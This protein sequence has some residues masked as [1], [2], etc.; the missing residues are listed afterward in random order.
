VIDNVIAINN[1]EA[2][3]RLITMLAEDKRT[4][5]TGKQPQALHPPPGLALY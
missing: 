1:P 4:R 3:P 5:I 2:V